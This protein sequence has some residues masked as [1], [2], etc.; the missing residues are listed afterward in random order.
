[1]N[2]MDFIK[3]LE[4]GKLVSIFDVC[5]ICSLSCNSQVKSLEVPVASCRGKAV[6]VPPMET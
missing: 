2:Y 6:V 5:D 3:F 1:M 4:S